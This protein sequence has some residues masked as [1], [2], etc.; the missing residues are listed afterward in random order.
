VAAAAEAVSSKHAERALR[1]NIITLSEANAP[2]YTAEIQCGNYSGGS[3]LTGKFPS[4]Y[5]KGNRG[6]SGI[7]FRYFTAISVEV[8]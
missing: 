7:L 3:I 8:I 5:G 4:Q 1:F 2:N 6:K